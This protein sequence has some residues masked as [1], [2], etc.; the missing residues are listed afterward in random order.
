M[1]GLCAGLVVLVGCGAGHQET[2]VHSPVAVPAPVASEAVMRPG[3]RG[4]QP[5]Y[6]EPDRKARLEAIRGKL[7]AAF[8]KAMAGQKVPGA[9]V[10]IVVGGEL[11]YSRAAGVANVETKAPVDVDTLFGIASITKTFT[12]EAVLKLRD[13]GK[14]GL[15]DPASRY[16]PEL[17]AVALPTN[18]ATPITLRHLLTHS[19]GLPRDAAYDEWADTREISEADMREAIP[20]L[21]MIGPPGVESSYSNVGFSLLGLVIGKA[22]GMRYRD[23]VA[24]ELLAPLGMTAAIWSDQSARN[25]KAATGYRLKK[26]ALEPASFY[27]HGASEADGGLVV[28]MRDMARYAAFQLTAYPPRDAQDT[29][30]LRRASLREAH[31][32]TVHTGL[33]VD[34]GE[35]GVD[36][37]ASGIGLAWHT[38]EDC[39]N[40]AVAWHSG[41]ISGFSSS[42]HLF[43]ASGVALLLEANLAS[44]NRGAFSI[45]MRHLL[46]EGGVLEPRKLQPDAAVERA[47]TAALKLYEK[48]NQDSYEATFATSFRQA[49]TPDAFDKVSEGLRPL[50]GAC[51]LGELRSSDSPRHA[52]YR[53]ACERGAIESTVGLDS[54]GKIESYFV[55][56]SGAHSPAL[57]AP[58]KALLDAPLAMATLLPVK[59][60]ARTVKTP[61]ATVAGEPGYATPAA[62][63]LIAEEMRKLRSAHGKCSLGEARVSGPTQ[64]HYALSCERGGDVDIAFTFDDKKAW[65]SVEVSPL[66]SSRKCPRKL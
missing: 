3:P 9:V 54:D 45:P 27:H 13:E 29:G 25:P 59:V 16:V 19:A 36:A 47:A 28:S 1:R 66:A 22:S 26:D 40:D 42:I 35:Y 4:P 48:M 46:L 31:R 61:A 20:K 56:S 18:D 8:D 38:Y 17:G 43:P 34:Q 2:N 21:V 41:L 33:R 63:D 49:I 58:A 64:Q 51:K 65:V 50:H 39:D 24:R 11:V 6:R 57:D 55:R 10:G 14:L 60:T 52:V 62:R 44:T 32:T 15:D 23:Y 53:Y 12:A 7:D 30:P 37:S 5:T